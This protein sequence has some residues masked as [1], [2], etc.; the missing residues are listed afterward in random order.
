MKK[1]KNIIIVIIS[2]IIAIA[3][4]LA[5]IFA[6]NKNNNKKTVQS[7]TENTYPTEEILKEIR[8]S[9]AETPLKDY[10]LETIINNN[11]K[12]KITEKIEKKEA[13]IEFTTQYRDNSSL[14]KGKIQ[15]IQEG[16]DGKQNEIVRSTY[17]NGVLVATQPISV[18]VKKVAKDKIVE[19]GTGAYSANYVPIAGDKLKPIENEIDLKT[20]AN[21]ES[22]TIK[23][24]AKT[25]TV[26]IKE[27]KNDWYNVKIDNQTGWVPKSKMEYVNEAENA[28]GGMPVYTKE[29]LT[30]NFGISM[31]L[32]RRSGLTL[33][34]FK[35]ILANDPND[36]QNV[37]KNIY[38][39]FYFVEQ[40]YNINGLFVA[41][42]AVHESGWGTS[43]LSLRTK[44]LFGY[45]AYDRDPSAYA[46]Q[47]GAYE[48]GI[49]LVSRVLVKYYL[50]PK[51]TQIYN[52]EIAQGT[53]FHG[54]TVTGVNTSYASDKR[55]GEK[56][57]K[58][59]TY[60]YNK[61]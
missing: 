2:I 13:D 49:D 19:V 39:Y 12:E 52:G 28:D 7:E 53:Y 55:W 32:N 45:G 22:N 6:I 5:I 8:Q 46:N 27:A 1:R 50:N 59:M 31:L 36:K 33:E 38:Q 51:G 18:E 56:V 48:S 17:K 4:A 16:Q 25:D 58:W 61:L 26:V 24:L 42:I 37:F 15:T 54:A 35:Q 23:K 34:Q 47:F 9:V 30:Q 11:E 60:F 57:Y 40:Q 21:Q 10:N 20:D 43:A 44:N 29:Q 3:L 41:A 14:A